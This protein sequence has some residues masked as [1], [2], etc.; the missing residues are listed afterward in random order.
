ML[1]LISTKMDKKMDVDLQKNIRNVYVI[2]TNRN[3][4][5]NIDIILSEHRYD[6]EWTPVEVITPEIVQLR[7]AH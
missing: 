6:N 2:C 7:N 5:I 3:V 4:R 1:R